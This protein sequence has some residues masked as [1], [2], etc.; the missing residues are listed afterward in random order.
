MPTASCCAGGGLGQE[1]RSEKD[2][3]WVEVVLGL[4]AR[5]KRTVSLC[6]AAGKTDYP[7]WGRRDEINS[8]R[9]DP[10]RVAGSRRLAPAAA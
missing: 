9:Q 2:V 8:R 5:S 3:V 1:P 10:D 7:L 6:V 4:T